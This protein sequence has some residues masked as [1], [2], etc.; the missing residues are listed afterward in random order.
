MLWP[1][2]Q[3][4]IARANRRSSVQAKDPL[5][6]TIYGELILYTRSNA[7]CALKVGKL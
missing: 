4:S 1:V 5:L 6:Y 7:L 3:I 2:V